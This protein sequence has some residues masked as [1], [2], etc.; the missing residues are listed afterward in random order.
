[1]ALVEG[2]RSDVS[3][4]L[5]RPRHPG[6]NRVVDIHSFQQT[7]IRLI[8]GIVLAHPDLLADDALLLGYALRREP[9]HRY[10]RQQRA[11]IVLESSHSVEKVAGHGRGRERVGIRPVGSHALER[12]P[13]LRI[14]GLVLQEMG[15]SRRRVQPFA[16][17][18]SKAHVHP[19]IPGGEKGK[20]FAVLRAHIH[21][22]VQSIRQHAV[23][24]RLAQ[25]GVFQLIH[26]RPPPFP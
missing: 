23:G 25:R 22:N 8:I 3:D 10:E 26:S 17:L 14:E 18:T 20:L 15:H 9:R 13:I 7:I 11:Q 16:V 2:I 24:Y 12:V 21:I 19:T 5:H 1:M 4:G 6:T